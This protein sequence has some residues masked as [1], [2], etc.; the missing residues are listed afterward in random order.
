LFGAK[1]KHTRNILLFSLLAL[2]CLA[3]ALLGSK[4][5][6]VS[7]LM[8]IGSAQGWQVRTL[9]GPLTG[10]VFQDYNANGIRDVSN[11][12]SNNGSGQI[13]AAFDRGV[14][15]VTV[16]AYDAGG[17]VA[18]T[19]TTNSDGTYTINATGSGPY[20]LEFT[21]LP[22]GFQ[23]GPVGADSRT[24][25]RFISSA[26]ENNLDFGIVLPMAFCQDNPQLVTSCYVGGGQQGT[27]P[28]IVTFPYSSGSARD[29]GGSPFSDFDAPTHGNLARENQVGTTW[30]LAYAR[31][32]RTLY[33][34]A[35]M[36][37]H[38]G[39]GPAGP[40]AIYRIDPATGNSSLYVNL[41]AI[42][43]GIAGNDPHQASDFDRDNGNAAWDAVGKIGFGGLALNGAET[44]LYAMNLAERALYEFPTDTTPNAGNLRKRAVPTNP[45]GCANAGDVR[46]FAVHWN[47]GRLFVGLTC[48]AESTGNAG[49]L[50]AY[51]YSVDPQT[52]DFSAQPV[53]QTA[54]NYQRRCADNAQNGPPNCFSA[55]WRAWSPTYQNIGLDGRGIYPQPWLT[56]I[57]FDRGDLILGLRDRAGDQFGNNTLDNPADNVRYYGVSAG[58]TLRA[59]GNL[60]SGWTLEANGRCGGQGSA[61]QNT[62]EGPGNGEYYFRDNAPPF[63]DENGVGGLLQIPGFADLVVNSSD[64][65]PLLEFG[66]LFDGGPLWMNNNSGN[67]SKSYRVYDGVLAFDLLGKANGLGD[68]LALCDPA[69]LELGN[70]IWRDANGNGIQDVGEPGIAGVVVQLFKN[71]IKVGETTTNS[72]GSYL[73][74]ASNVPGGVLPQMNYEICVDRTQAALAGSTLTARDADA[75]DN[76]DARDSD[77]EIDGS[78]ARIQLTTLGPGASNH[79]YDIG[80]L[81]FTLTCPPNQTVTAMAGATSAVV[82]YPAPTVTPAGATVTC[83]PASGTSFAVGTTTVTCTATFGG[84]TQSC[85]FTVTVLAPPTITCPANLRLTATSATGAIV[86]YPAPTTT[87]AGVTVTCTPASGANFPVGT[88][89]VTCTATN[90][91]GSASC[92]FTVTVDPPVKCDTICYRAP[93]WWLLNLDNLPMGT[94]QIV[95][96][97][98]E[99]YL[100]TSNKAAIKLALQGNPFGFGFTTRQS[101]NQEYVAAQL[102]ILN[103]G[104]G[105]SPVVYN[106]MW[107]NLSC[108]RIT[109]APVTLSNGVT[110]T[111]GSM[112]KELYMQITLAIQQRREVDYAPLARILDLLN[113]NDARGFCNR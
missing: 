62:G 108:Y 47:E 100:S 93:Q 53:F 24:N 33:A 75:T 77:A 92:S 3:A 90:T 88:T 72:M 82:N 38:A 66:T 80:F 39:F 59:C 81:T 86:T 28:V 15:G 97:N 106:S 41:N 96:A 69:P 74:N 102:N 109:F 16:T 91:A 21:N 11:A 20:R 19:T 58:D 65:I 4:H 61:P 78:C 25:V 98:G 48:T 95:G 29:S 7:A 42:T 50:A 46:P 54:L 36:K 76:G 101:F 18:G 26:S 71:G 17:A 64:P 110:L 112:V 63:L 8:P 79:S 27:N 104:G 23:P 83:T 111:T 30:G 14:G 22:A 105:G 57:A 49:Q 9:A 60:A 43:A 84:A 55:A 70:R 12:L 87:G 56:D 113:G 40:G 6:F 37:K 45:P 94:V 89:T 107:A 44:R 103:A 67:R 2:L 35:F 1:Q 5:S 68:L 13:P 73:F 34:S 52:L 32:S 31:S 85:Q 10:I 99:Q 51:V